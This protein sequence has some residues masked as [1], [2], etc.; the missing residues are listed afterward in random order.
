MKEDLKDALVPALK[1][2]ITGGI[3]VAARKG[4]IKVLKNT[5][6]RTI[7]SVVEVSFRSVD[8]IK[9]M[10]RGEISFKE[11]VKEIGKNAVSVAGGVFG[12]M[13]GAAAGAIIGG[14]IGALAGGVVGGILGEKASTRVA[15]K[16]VNV[17]RTVKEKAVKAYNSVKNTIKSLV[18]GAKTA[19]SFEAGS[20]TVASLEDLKN[21]LRESPELLLLP[22]QDGRLERFLKGI[23]GKLSDCID[24]NSPEESI[25]KLAEMLDIEIKKELKMD[26]ISVVTSAEELMKLLEEGRG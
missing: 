13:K 12:A 22:A 14:P 19:L 11:G 25:K 4:L 24:R 15:E 26:G 20:R 8:T 9:K 21:L 17:A 16:V 7:A 2:A 6:A 5:P 23:S 1:T 10:I 3:I 18:G